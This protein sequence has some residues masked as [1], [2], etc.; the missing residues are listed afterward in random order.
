L[1][2]SPQARPPKRVNSTKCSIDEKLERYF[3]VI[4]FQ[5]STKKFTDLPDCDAVLVRDVAA[6]LEILGARLNIPLDDLDNDVS[7]EPEDR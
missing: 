7:L 5:R 1:F 2:F 6:F 3:K 4:Y